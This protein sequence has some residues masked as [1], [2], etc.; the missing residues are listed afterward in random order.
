MPE[1]FS[2]TQQEILIL[3]NLAVNFQFMESSKCLKYS[4]FLFVCVR[5]KECQFSVFVMILN[6]RLVIRLTTNISE[7][8]HMILK[9]VLTNDQ[10]KKVLNMAKNG[11]KEG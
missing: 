4:L 5:V 1:Y 7:I 3:K 2:E 10:G 11:L 6:L 9:L 8:H